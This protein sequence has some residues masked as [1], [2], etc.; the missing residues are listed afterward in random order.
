[1]LTLLSRMQYKSEVSGDFL[2]GLSVENHACLCSV[3][4]NVAHETKVQETCTVA[5]G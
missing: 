2:K 5:A 4:W 3:Q 1:M